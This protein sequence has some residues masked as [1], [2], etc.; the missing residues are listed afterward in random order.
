MIDEDEE[1][2]VRAAALQALSDL[3]DPELMN[4]IGSLVHDDD[5][6]VRKIA[7]S[8]L[9]TVDPL[10]AIEEAEYVLQGESTEEKQQVIQMLCRISEQK[11]GDVL[12][13]ALQRQ[14]TSEAEM[15]IRLDLLE[16]AQERGE[17]GLIVSLVK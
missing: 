10:A 11:A 16:A 8:I 3:H 2:K 5:T 13:R 12:V 7:R 15:S 4:S 14:L 17:K 6:E 9:A 1:S